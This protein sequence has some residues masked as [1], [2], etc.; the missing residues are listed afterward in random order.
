M[1]FF[2]RA[3]VVAVVAAVSHAPVVLCPVY[4]CLRFPVVVPVVRLLEFWIVLARLSVVRVVVLVHVLVFSE[5]VR[6][7]VFVFVDCPVVTVVS[8]SVVYPYR[9]LMRCRMLL[10]V[11]LSV[12]FLTF[13]VVLFVFVS[14]RPG[15]GR[16][17]VVLTSRVRER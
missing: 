8:I 17:T 11:G 3:F 1:C 5:H 14:L 16:L 4:S 13:W 2:C 7:L 6:V 9:V 12:Y 15:M 10:P